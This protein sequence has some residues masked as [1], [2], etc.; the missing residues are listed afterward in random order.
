MPA[1]LQRGEHV[2]CSMCACSPGASGKLSACP[3]D[4]SCSNESVHLN[5]M[6]AL[7]KASGVDV[8]ESDYPKLATLR[9]AVDY[10]AQRITV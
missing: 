1:L 3:P 8:P 6:I 2:T 4:Y 10:L 7:H 9:D 5:F